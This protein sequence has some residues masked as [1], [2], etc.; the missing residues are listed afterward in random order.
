MR[1]FVAV[2][3]DDASRAAVVHEQRRLARAFGD[4]SA[5]KWV[6]ADQIHLTL[7]FMG[8]VEGPRIE[9]VVDAM[10][11]HL[12]MAPF[13]LAFGGLDTFPSRSAPRVL[14]LG[15]V[16]GRQDLGD[17]QRVVVHRL[18]SLDVELEDPSFHPHLTL[19][20]WRDPQRSAVSGVRAAVREGEIACVTVEAVTLF[21]SRL[22]PVGATHIPMCRAQLGEEPSQPL[23]S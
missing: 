6:S 15:V 1:L 14:W 22:S 13:E 12:S 18:R 10:R 19:G 23:Q 11:R 5:I 3:L 9:P 21:Q 7:A 2:E 4:R 16:R 8:E 20:R 17:V